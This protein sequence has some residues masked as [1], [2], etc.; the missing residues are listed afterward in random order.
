V[1]EDSRDALPLPTAADVE[2]AAQLLRGRLVET[3]CLH[4]R[5][6]SELTGAQVY[7][8]FENLQFTASFKE[9]G[10]L[11]KLSSLSP[12]ARAAGV[13]AASAGNHAQAV[14]W[15][16]KQLGIPATIV[17]PRQTPDVKVEHT[18][19]FGAEVVLAGDSF[20]AALA[21]AEQLSR[22]RGLTLVHPYDDPLVIA[23]QGTVA[24][25]MLDAV[26][27]LECLVAPV[28]GG[29][30]V[31]GMALAARARNPALRVVG[32]EPARIPSM[33][34]ALR[35]EPVPPAPPTVADGL[36]VRQV[37]R[38]T[39]EL[40]RRHVDELLCVEE[41]EIETALLL[42]LEVEKTVVE[43]AGA[44]ALAAL[45]AHRERFAGRHVGL[46]LSGGNIDP[47]RLSGII[48]RG[49]VRSARLTSLRVRVRDVTQA[50]AEILAILAG[51]DARVVAIR[52]ERAFTG[53]SL[54]AV[55]V[56][57]VLET[58]GP[59]HVR[60]IVE[61]LNEAGYRPVDL[62]IGAR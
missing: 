5:T 36:A 11:N 19:A 27:Q 56:D 40:V 39:Q 12:A 52:H 31:A 38:L 35:G 48:E 33:A 49:L 46:V 32:V 16:A 55:D 6:L 3:P 23:G 25:E 53:A 44:V 13:V 22:Q 61:A 9:R 41:S 18:R 17:M 4:A 37:G 62:Q 43:G 21:H 54:D 42:L 29:G 50:L 34:C 58:R 28:G 2:R 30:L 20:E 26:P 15:H 47:L 59:A 8:K 1:S 45:L 7:L 51:V 60:Q 24:L 57:C 10:A 14:A